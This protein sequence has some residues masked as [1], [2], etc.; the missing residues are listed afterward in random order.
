MVATDGPSAVESVR[1][2]R[3]DL[4]IL[5]LMLP[6]FDG[7]EVCRRVRQFRDAYVLILTARAEEIDPIVGLE[8]GA[9]DYLTKPFSPRALIARVK[10]MLR[11]PRSSMSTPSDGPA[12]APSA[13]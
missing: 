5:D 2:F 3:P 12:P 1:K 13:S 4:I 7:L 8:V 9:D 6:D 11:R 10:A